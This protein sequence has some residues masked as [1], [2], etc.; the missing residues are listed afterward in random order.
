MK[1]LLP[2]F[3]LIGLTTLDAIAEAL[4]NVYAVGGRLAW[5]GVAV[6]LYAVSCGLY[7]GLLR[8]YGF[9]I[10]TSV[11]TVLLICINLFVAFIAF[12]ERFSVQH[13]VGLLIAG[14]GIVL[15]L[16]TPSQNQ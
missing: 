2:V 3:L 12:G 4:L 13:V 1:S 10:S 9:A 5:F 6:L 8:I 14:L 11:S 15:L 7:V 16:N